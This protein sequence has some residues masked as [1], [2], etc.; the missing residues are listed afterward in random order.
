MTGYW[1]E[2][3]MMEPAPPPS[4]QA[5]YQQFRDRQRLHQFLMNLRPLFADRCCTEILYLVSRQ[6]TVNFKLRRVIN[7]IGYIVRQSS[8]LAIPLKYPDRN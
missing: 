2:L 8:P 4:F 7:I 5:E 3:Q 6:P 1:R